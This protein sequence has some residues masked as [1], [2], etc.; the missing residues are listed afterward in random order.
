[1]A[2]A[3]LKIINQNVS[4]ITQAISASTQVAQFNLTFSITY[5]IVDPQGKVII[6]S[7][8]INIIKSYS[9]N[10]NQINSEQN[11]KNIALP[12]L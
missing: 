9:V 1:M 5:E 8:I 7:K 11:Q 10:T 4:V 3:I 2:N 12:F 6:P